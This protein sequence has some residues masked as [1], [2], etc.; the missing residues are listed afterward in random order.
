MS[1]VDGT[2]C[3][4]D[5]TFTHNENETYNLSSLAG[6]KGPLPYNNHS[7]VLDIG[8][9]LPEN[10]ECYLNGELVQSFSCLFYESA[11][12]VLSMVRRDDDRKLYNNNASIILEYTGG[13]QKPGCDGEGDQLVTR[14]SFFCDIH[15]AA[16][17]GELNLDELSPVSISNAPSQDMQARHGE[18]EKCLVA[19]KWTNF[20]ACRE[21]EEEDYDQRTSACK[22]GA[23]HVFYLRR[24]ECY[25]ANVI[26]SALIKCHEIF[27][28]QPWVILV[29]I[30]FVCGLIVV[31]VAIFIRHNRLSQRYMALEQEKSK[32]V[33]MEE[34]EGSE[35]GVNDD[36]VVD[37]DDDDAKLDSRV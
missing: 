34:I 16:I 19:L 15:A 13:G 14:I 22:D 21:C 28:I 33:E 23:K 18:N 3:A 29:V 32:N 27:E 1:S 31:L 4:T 30:L 37:D 10:G 8:N 9:F 6:V 12:T 17:P 25:G 5:C 26:K 35:I 24:S 7:V 2:R 36:D 20:A 11:G